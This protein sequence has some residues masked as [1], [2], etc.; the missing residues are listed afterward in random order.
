[1]S[2]LHS[3]EL[4]VHIELPHHKIH[5]GEHNNLSDKRNLSCSHHIDLSEQTTVC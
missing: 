2:H 3:I 1:M 5:C 4:L